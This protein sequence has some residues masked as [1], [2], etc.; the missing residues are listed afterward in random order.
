MGK[1]KT[2][3]EPFSAEQQHKIAQLKSKLDIFA[4][5]LRE[6]FENY[7]LSVALVPPRQSAA[8][9]QINLVVIVNDSDRKKLSRAELK[10]K[11]TAIV[12]VLAK[13]VDPSLETE[14]ILLS[15]LWNN[16]LCGNY[17]VVDALRN[18]A[19]VYDRSLIAALKFAA[20]HKQ[21]ALDKFENY[22]LSY[23]LTGAV[24]RGES[25]EQSPIKITVIVD[26]TD[27][28]SMHS[29]ELHEKLRL[30][31]SHL[32]AEVT[33][34]LHISHAITVETALLSE[35]WQGLYR[36][37]HATITLIRDGIPLYDRGVFAPW[38]HLLAKGCFIP[39]SESGEASIALAR[40]R[41]A[42]SSQQYAT[43]VREDLYPAI[44]ET[45]T[46]ALLH[47]NLSPQPVEIAHLLNEMCVKPGLLEKE[48]LAT[49][50]RIRDL[51]QQL[52]R[53]PQKVVRGRDVDQLVEEAERF[54]TRVERLIAQRRTQTRTERIAELVQRTIVA[55]KSVLSMQG[56]PDIHEDELLSTMNT[57]LVQS[58]KLSERHLAI[59]GSL[60]K[61]RTHPLRS[62]VAVAERLEREAQEL[63]NELILCSERT[64]RIERER[65]KVRMKHGA[66]Q[67]EV[68]FGEHALYIVQDLE[69]PFETVREV[70]V[71]ADGS[72]GEEKQIPWQVYQEKT[73]KGASESVKEKTLNDLKKMLKELFQ[74]DIELFLN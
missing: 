7:V 63:L 22:I 6:K 12:T 1:D 5:K 15:E 51:Q 49:F 44:L 57:V 55:S 28:K 66:T 52:A 56:I 13:D 64:Q 43:T 27:V 74:G 42:R 71:Y 21:L 46:A 29:G 18:T 41:L 26:N 20:A 45:T 8:R 53:D 69:H 31:L 50:V 9:H 68:F 47:F 40:E 61:L 62:D 3:I 72:L 23:I 16:C 25:T 2:I 10:K 37:D 17:A 19:V 70:K 14:T 4:A 38:K 36:A 73:K 24:A 59:L 54:V 32:I 11:V 58:G 67:G 30:I 39:S 34:M 65:H 35:L 48:Y 60:L 33:E